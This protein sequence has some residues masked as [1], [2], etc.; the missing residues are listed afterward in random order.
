MS[1]NHFKCSI[2][3]F[4][5]TKVV[6]R[7]ERIE[8]PGSGGF[9]IVVMKS[10]VKF[11]IVL[12]FLCLDVTL[13]SEDAIPF[14]FG[15]CPKMINLVASGIHDFV[16]LFVVL[17]NG[18]SFITSDQLGNSTSPSGTFRHFFTCSL[19]VCFGAIV[20]FASF[21]I[22][23]AIVIVFLFGII[24]GSPIAYHRRLAYAALTF[25]YLHVFAA[26]SRTRCLRCSYRDA[27][28][29]AIT[30]GRW[31]PSVACPR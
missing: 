16:H 6:I 25:H 10:V 11:M 14:L 29:I 13:A 17:L 12:I 5:H 8:E 21:V 7:M 27:C 2:R 28:L 19:L 15:F 20:M 9:V 23:V 18:A 22:L 24:F 4:V 26:V 3:C 1:S 31:E 30:S